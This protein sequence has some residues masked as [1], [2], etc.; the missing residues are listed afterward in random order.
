MN[1]Q[2]AL[3]LPTRV[4]FSAESFVEGRANDEARQ[5]LARWADWPRR[6]LALTG[7]AGTGKSHLAT[8]WAKD[9]GAA[10]VEAGQ[11]ADI[12]PDLPAGQALV[13]EDL[14]RHMPEQALFHAINRAAEGDIPALLLT[15]RGSP[16]LWT[17][18]LPDLA[19]RL[20]ALPHV[21]LHEP[22]DALLTLVMEK[23]FQDRGAPVNKG[24]IDYLLPRMDR[25]VGAARRLVDMMDKLAL[26]R[27]SPVTR[28][29][30]RDAL[31]ALMDEEAGE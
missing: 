28:S 9:V 12:L 10:L 20:R 19:S 4:D 7:P 31:E 15:G 3:N 16:V 8:I 17:A 27:K 18:E 5:A 26:V 11:L 29:V 1:E 25:S 24:V 6:V 23:Q 13:V 14:D 22:D 21:D 30:A 2:L